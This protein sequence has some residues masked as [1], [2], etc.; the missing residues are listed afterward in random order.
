MPATLTVPNN[1]ERRLARLLRERSEQAITGRNDRVAVARQL[2]LAPSGLDALLWQKEW[3]IE[4]ALRVAVALGVIDDDNVT[5][6]IERS[7]K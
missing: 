1:V 4:Q 6:L 2:G 3:P 7:T 5:N